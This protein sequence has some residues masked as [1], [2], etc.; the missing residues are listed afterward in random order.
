MEPTVVALLLIAIT[1]SAS[2]HPLESSETTTSSPDDPSR[3]F[4]TIPQSVDNAAQAPIKSADENRLE[5]TLKMDESDKEVID[6]DL[7]KYRVRKEN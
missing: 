4:F 1:V 5:I 2:S 6:S 3:I 7:G